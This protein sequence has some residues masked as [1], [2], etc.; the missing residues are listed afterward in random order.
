LPIFHRIYND[1]D[2]SLY[3]LTA[4]SSPWPVTRLQHGQKSS[5][6]RF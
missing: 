4:R 3:T 1:A 2:L 6:P 5:P